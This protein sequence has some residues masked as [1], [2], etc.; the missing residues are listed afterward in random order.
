[1]ALNNI[2]RTASSM[3]QPLSSLAVRVLFDPPRIILGKRGRWL[4]LNVG[5]KSS[6]VLDTSY[7]D[8]LLRI[9]LGGRSGTRFVFTRCDDE[10]ASD[11]R[12]LLARRSWSKP[13]SLLTLSALGTVGMY[14]ALL[15]GWKIL[16]TTLTTMSLALITIV[17]FSSGGI[18]QRDASARQATQQFQ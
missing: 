8:N 18:E 2:E 1:M 12:Q 5:P 15:Q 17:G 9:G 6:V 3:C 11:F 13:K 7:V 10:E 16:G 4:N 14:A